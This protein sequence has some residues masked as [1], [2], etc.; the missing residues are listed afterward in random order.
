MMVVKKPSS[1]FAEQQISA[2]SSVQGLFVSAAFET[3]GIVNVKP[4][5]I[6]LGSAFSEGSASRFIGQQ[7]GQVNSAFPFQAP[8]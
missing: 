4:P 1:S 7:S 5:V 3:I 8:L 2:I 6:M